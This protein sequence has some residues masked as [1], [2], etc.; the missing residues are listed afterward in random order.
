MTLEI[1]N[2]ADSVK[3]QFGLLRMDK[4]KKE[5]KNRRVR[6]YIFMGKGF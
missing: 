5:K 2:L 6:D 4:A 1:V 3:I